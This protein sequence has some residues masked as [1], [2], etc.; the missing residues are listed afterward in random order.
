MLHRLE[1]KRGES[2]LTPDAIHRILAAS[3]I[4]PP[5]NERFEQMNKSLFH[6]LTHSKSIVWEPERVDCLANLLIATFK[7]R[8]LLPPG[9]VIAKIPGIFDSLLTKDDLLPEERLALCQHYVHPGMMISSSARDKLHTI[10]HDIAQSVGSSIADKKLNPIGKI[11]SSLISFGTIAAHIVPLTSDEIA[12]YARLVQYLSDMSPTSY[13]I[14]NVLPS[15]SFLYQSHSRLDLKPL[16]D[17]II[18]L[19][20]TAVHHFE[21]YCV[22]RHSPGYRFLI[23]QNASRICYEIFEELLSRL[24]DVVSVFTN[25]E[26]CDAERIAKAFYIAGL[27]ADFP[28]KMDCRDV[29]TK[30]FQ[31]LAV[32]LIRSPGIGSSSLDDLIAMLMCHYVSLEADEDFVS[33]EIFQLISGLGMMACNQLFTR[34]PASDKGQTFGTLLERFN[35]FILELDMFSVDILVPVEIL[36]WIGSM[37][38]LCDTRPDLN[39]LLDGHQFWCADLFLKRDPDLSDEQQEKLI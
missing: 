34:F 9:T 22:N 11:V 35:T 33:E 21:L 13:V 37:A 6:F 5:F 14:D 17:A 4:L 2:I 8:F 20:K 24:K 26:F 30:A 28:I 36:L 39:P 38:E 32:A 23:D 29:I 27:L 15:L 31:V 7:A 1:C 25:E 18:R 3:K 10:L 12:A 16:D 19:M